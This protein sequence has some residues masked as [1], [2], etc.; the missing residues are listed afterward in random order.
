MQLNIALDPSAVRILED[1]TKVSA[2]A[3]GGVYLV[4]PGAAEIF[5]MS[6]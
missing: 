2:S 3:Y 5:V 4:S 6:H 1:G